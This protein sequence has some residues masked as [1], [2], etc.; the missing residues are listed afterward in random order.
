[1]RIEW[2]LSDTLIHLIDEFQI[3]RRI[4]SDY[5][6]GLLTNIPM[7]SNALGEVNKHYF[8]EDSISSNQK[9]DYKL[10]ARQTDGK[11]LLIDKYEFFYPYNFKEGKFLRSIYIPLE[12]V[13]HKDSITIII[14]EYATEKILESELITYSRKDPKRI[15]Y[16][17]NKAIQN[18]YDKLL[19]KVINNSSK[20]TREYVFRLW[21]E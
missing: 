2:E 6:H 17:T 9:Y 5:K 11:L 21:Q 19:V 1:V 18:Y 8:F 12:N 16:R 10:V 13:K 14:Y 7:A 4:E 3:F 15:E 20:I